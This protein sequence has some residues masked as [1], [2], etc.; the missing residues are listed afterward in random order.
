MRTLRHPFLLPGHPLLMPRP[1]QAIRTLPLGILIVYPPASLY[2]F[3][4][5]AVQLPATTAPDYSPLRWIS[6]ISVSQSFQRLIQ[7]IWVA[8][9]SLRSRCKR[10]CPG[11]EKGCRGIRALKLWCITGS[12][13]RISERFRN[14]FRLLNQ[15]RSERTDKQV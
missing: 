12:I 7:F 8:P 15:R 5:V 1:P 10:G 6:S 2:I 4:Q 13:T 14:H 11:N 9:G 3:T